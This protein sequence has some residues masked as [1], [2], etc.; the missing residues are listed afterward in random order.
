MDD[1]RTDL[2]GLE[3]RIVSVSGGR[4]FL[5]LIDVIAFGALADAIKEFCNPL[6]A[7]APVNCAVF[8][9]DADPDTLHLDHLELGELAFYRLH[10]DIVLGADAGS[11]HQGSEVHFDLSPFS[12]V[13]ELGMSLTGS[14]EAY[15]RKYLRKVLLRNAMSEPSATTECI[16]GVS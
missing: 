2:P 10:N 15:L 1:L 14:R 7:H 9:T 3:N 12:L 4:L 8:I 13:I 5:K 6:H 11:C 16:E